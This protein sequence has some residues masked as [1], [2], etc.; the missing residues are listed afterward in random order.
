MALSFPDASFD[1]VWSV[2][3]GPHMPDKAI[4]AKELLRVVKP[5]GVLVVADWNQRDDR[6]IPLNVW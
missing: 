5:G 6:Q 4:F 3:A 1:V 2:E